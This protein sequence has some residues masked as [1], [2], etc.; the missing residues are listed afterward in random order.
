[1]KRHNLIP[2]VLGAALV[3]AACG[4]SDDDAGDAAATLDDPS[5][6]DAGTPVTLLM[7][8]PYDDP[9]WNYTPAVGHFVD[10]IE[11]MSGG[12]I[13]VEMIWAYGD[14]EPDAEQ[15]IVAAVAAGEVELAWVGTRVFDTLGVN[16]FQALHA[17]LL[18]DSYE[19]QEAILTSD[20]PGQMLAGLDNID[21]AGLAIL[22]GGLRKPIA[23]DGPLLGPDDYAGATIQAFRSQTQAETVMALGATPTDV[24][25]GDR[26][27]G[28]YGGEIQGIEN[29]LRAF[30]ARD[31]AWY[32][33]YV[34]ANVNL[35]PETQVLLV[36][37]DTLAALSDEQAGWLRDA[38]ADAAARSADL[39]DGDSVLVAEAC[40]QGGRF[41]EASESEL[42]ALRDAVG[43]V[44]TLLESDSVTAELIVQI[45]FL[46]EAVSAEPL[47]I[48]DG[49]TGEA[50]AVAAPGEGS[51]ALPPG[52]Y[53]T[54]DMTVEE[55]AAT[56]EA[57][58]FDADEA[59]ASAQEDG[60]QSFAVTVTIT[61]EGRWQELCSENGGPARPCHSATIEVDGD[62]VVL[63]WDCTTTMRFIVDD[64]A[65][66]FEY[67]GVECPDPAEAGE[68]L[69]WETM[70]YSTVPFTRVD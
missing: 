8:S 58:G 42:A 14:F 27:A 44:Y 57:A 16:T 24:G 26:D 56:A 33:P 7:A 53:T 17:P 48:P 12:G 67:L 69:L 66:H 13:A 38:A 41:A 52:T 36:N 6:E 25:P 18:V 32:V 61:E 45:S 21:V 15:Q 4:S 37:P 28:L 50:S 43:P 59:E 68:H 39:H 54:G 40:D 64:D 65:L 70:I 46:K 55:M 10:T 47:A 3:L 35:W 23:V 20:V 49:C 11:A 30:V 19:L 31:M 1:M 63:S 2:V 22:A 5:G 29:T 60:V 62:R 34:T 9:G 51:P